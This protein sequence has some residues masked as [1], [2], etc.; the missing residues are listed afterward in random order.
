MKKICPKCKEEFECKH[1]ENCFCMK[2]SISE[3][4]LNILKKEFDNC[5]C[6]DCLK[7][8]AIKQEETKHKLS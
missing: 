5:L 4:N 1:N 8:Y 6:E 2:Y 7:E 3:Q